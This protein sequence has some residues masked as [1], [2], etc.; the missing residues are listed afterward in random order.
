MIIND[1]DTSVVS[2][3]IKSPYKF[4]LG[5]SR[6]MAQKSPG[7]ITIKPE[8]D[9]D[10]YCDGFSHEGSEIIYFLKQLGFVESKTQPEYYD[11]ECVIIFKHS[12][13]VQVVIRKDAKFYCNVFESID[14]TF[15]Y[16][17]LWKS[18]P[19]KPDPAMIMPIFN[20]LFKTARLK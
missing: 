20:Q 7:I 3:L 2:Q 13:N 18:S 11:D 15:Y 14:P 6:R 10:F 4:Y 9:Y 5:G 16:H 17:F 1:V 12:D 19:V 8:T